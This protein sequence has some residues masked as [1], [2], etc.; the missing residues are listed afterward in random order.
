MTPSLCTLNGTQ[1][2][3]LGGLGG[4]EHCADNLP[5]CTTLDSVNVSA[6]LLSGATNTLTF[7]VQQAGDQRYS[8][9]SG[10]DFNASLTAV[11]EPSTLLMLGTGLMGSA[12]ALYRRMRS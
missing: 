5:N 7:V 6:A 12:G 9:P 8:D 11:P 3:F 1:I 2:V 10:V 4:N